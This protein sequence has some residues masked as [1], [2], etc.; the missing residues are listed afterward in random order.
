MNSNG[1]T[2][3]SSLNLELLQKLEEKA[4]QE[5]TPT[6]ISLTPPIKRQVQPRS[7]N[8]GVFLD[9]RKTRSALASFED[10]IGGR[11]VLIETLGMAQLDKKQEHFLRILCDP[12]RA[13]DSLATVCKDCNVLPSQVIDLFRTASF[14]KAHAIGMG[15]ISE[16]VPAIMQDIADKSVDKVVICPACRGE[17]LMLGACSRC[18]GTGEVLRESDIDRQKIALEVT[19]LTKKGGGVNVQVNQQVNNV[20][21]SS[22]FSKYVRSSDE[23]AYDVTVPTVD[24]EV[25]D[26]KD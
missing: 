7:E 22:F 9:S 24:G 6:S 14:A 13:Q 21:A 25:N 4:K 19:G 12:A 17:A 26:Q 11:D 23:A 5:T 10:A 3:S 15:V 20:G 18:N 2:E 8:A 16:A 1:Q